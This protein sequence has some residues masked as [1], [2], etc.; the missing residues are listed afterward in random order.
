M[1]LNYLFKSA[2]FAFAGAIFARI[3]GYLFKVMVARYDTQLYGLYS[4]GFSIIMF[5]IP[6]AMLG[7]GV[8]LNRYIN[9][10]QTKNEP[11]KANLA[12]NTALKTAVPLSLFAFLAIF[13]LSDTIAGFFDVKQLSL[14]LKL[15]SFVIPLIVLCQIS[16]SILL[17]NRKIK[18]LAFSRDFTQST[19]EI[20]TAG[21]LLYLGY[22]IHA[23]A[24]AFI[25]SYLVALLLALYFSRSYYKFS[26]KGYDS[27]LIAFS[28]P[29]MITFI[30]SGL[31]NNTSTIILGYFSNLKE[32]AFYNVA[33]PTAQLLAVISASFLSAFLPIITEK[34]AKNESIETEYQTVSRWILIST[35]PFALLMMLFSNKVVG[36]LFGPGFSKATIP[37]GILSFSVLMFAIT[38]TSF[39][40][41]VMLKKTKLLLNISL[42]TLILNV[43]LNVL[44]IPLSIKYYEHGLYGSAVATALSMLFLSI[45]TLLFAYKY[46]S[47]KAFDKPSL[48]IIFAG[49]LS[50]IPFY[51]IKISVN[52]VSEIFMILYLI[53]FF[54]LYTLILFAFN[55]FT[56]DDISV[57]H[58]I[59]N[60]LKRAKEKVTIHLPRNRINTKT[61]IQEPLD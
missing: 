29:I 48:K 33:V 40:S 21:F 43:G 61:A 42:L 49:I 47:I 26:L 31:L 22:R 14:T 45:L 37:L 19:L 53:L 34:H 11:D 27:S 50:L 20:V 60:K 16:Y 38:R 41:L 51:L 36:F 1:S 7:L 6:F 44:L 10:Y 17:S 15:F 5:I 25:F 32:V 8:G 13:F 58:A 3:L 56:Q 12:I 24:F 30:I 55:C 23:L 59:L 35:L 4:L 2:V 39:H 46:T 52:D 9:H 18:L 54:V 28:I 57:Y